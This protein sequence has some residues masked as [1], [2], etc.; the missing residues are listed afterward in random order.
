MYHI[1]FYCHF[2][3]SLLHEY[4]KW[5]CYFTC[6]MFNAECIGMLGI[7]ILLMFVVECIYRDAWHAQD[8]F[9]IYSRHTRENKPRHKQ[10]WQCHLLLNMH[11]GRVYVPYITRVQIEPLSNFWAV[12][13][14][15]VLLICIIIY[16]ILFEKKTMLEYIWS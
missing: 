14:G 15:M 13:Q 2:L 16:V 5:L 11:E 12:W 9:C 10:H 8:Y 1:I 3:S 7:Q 6:S 4:L